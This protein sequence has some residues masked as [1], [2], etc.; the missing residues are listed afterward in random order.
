M[1]LRLFLDEPPMQSARSCGYYHEVSTFPD[2][3]KGEG[4]VSCDLGSG[5]AH[6]FAKKEESQG[7]LPKRTTAAITITP[8]AIATSTFRM[9]LP[10]DQCR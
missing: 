7:E 1:N 4:L 9:G 2:L 6:R 8:H 5:I 3:R 10:F